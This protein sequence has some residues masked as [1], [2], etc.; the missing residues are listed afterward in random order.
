MTMGPCCRVLC[1][2]LIPILLVS[3]RQHTAQTATAAPIHTI[4]GYTK[5]EGSIYFGLFPSSLPSP[6]CL[7]LVV[8]RRVH[9]SVPFILLWPL[10][11]WQVPCVL[12]LSSSTCLI[13]TVVYIMLSG[14]LVAPTESHAERK[15]KNVNHSYTVFSL[16]R[17][18][19]FFPKNRRI[20]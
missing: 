15:L 9:L 7:V 14:L 19:F 13:G 2:C 6:S 11:W 3:P 1:E 20:V 8:R 5:K 16:H 4:A 12:C 10:R 17:Y 18:S